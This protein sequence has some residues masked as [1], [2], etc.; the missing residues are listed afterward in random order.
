MRYA[1]SETEWTII[2]PIL[3]SRSRGVPN[4]RRV[5]DGIFWILRSGAPWR[6]MPERYGA[7]LSLNHA[8]A[9]VLKRFVDVRSALKSRRRL[10]ARR[11]QFVTPKRTFVRR[12][13]PD[14][15]AP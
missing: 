13:G 3:P 6:D 2:Q 10:A 7:F 12:S 1:L 8:R 4:G 5:L 9:A 14:N 11:R 15:L